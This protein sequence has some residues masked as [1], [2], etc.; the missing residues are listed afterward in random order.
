ME[1]NPLYKLE[2]G[3]APQSPKLP[4]G[5][6]E[7]EQ[8]AC[9]PRTAAHW[10]NQNP[11]PQTFHPVLCLNTPNT[12][13]TTSGAP[14]HSR[15]PRSDILTSLSSH[16][17]FILLASDCSPVKWGFQKAQCVRHRTTGY[18]SQA[19]CLYLKAKFSQSQDV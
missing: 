5:D 9:L 7:E 13:P 15:A 17:V 10:P 18:T 14:P 6:E 19:L 4:T 3:H 11:P 1:G 8:K 2:G 12:P 16:P